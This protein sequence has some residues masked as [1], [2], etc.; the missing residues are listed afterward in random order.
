MAAGWDRCSTCTG[1]LG[2]KAIGTLGGGYW[3]LQGAC[4]CPRCIHTL[5]LEGGSL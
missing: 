4:S 3:L 2:A 5:R 1:T